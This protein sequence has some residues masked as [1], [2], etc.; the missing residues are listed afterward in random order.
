LEGEVARQLRKWGVPA[1]R[2]VVLFGEP[3]NG[4][5][6]LTRIC[7]KH[8]LASGINVV[9]VEGKRRSVYSYDRSTMGIGDE[10]RRGAAAGPSLLVFEDIDLHCQARQESEAPASLAWSSREDNALAEILDFLD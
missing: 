9:I 7:A 2:G 10:L 5:T 1:K 8:A 6:V 3:G 4:K